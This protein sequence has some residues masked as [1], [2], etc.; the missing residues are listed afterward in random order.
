MRPVMSCPYRLLEHPKIVCSED[1]FSSK[2]KNYLMGRLESLTLELLPV[3]RMCNQST[4]KGAMLAPIR[5]GN[6]T[7]SLQLRCQPRRKETHPHHP[8]APRPPLRG[9]YSK[10]GGGRGHQCAI[11]CSLQE[12]LRLPTS[13]AN[14]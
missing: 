13:S 11:P 10:G 4:G 12:M 2:G 14:S 5:L 8:S 3:I 6:A 9:F 1:A 7:A